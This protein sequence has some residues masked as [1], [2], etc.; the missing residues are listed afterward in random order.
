MSRFFKILILSQDIWGNVCHFHISSWNLIKD[1]IS[2][3]KQIE[4]NS[5]HGFV[6]KK[7]LK[8]I[9]WIKNLSPTIACTV[10]LFK[11]SAFL[12]IFVLRKKEFWVLHYWINEMEIILLKRRKFTFPLYFLMRIS[13]I[14]FNIKERKTV[15]PLISYSFLKKYR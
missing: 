5:R 7:L 15:L 10:L 6:E 13:S 3:A 4:R 12:Q 2:Q 14:F 8:I 9:I 1:F 11:A